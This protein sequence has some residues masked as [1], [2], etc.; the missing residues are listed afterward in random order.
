MQP[1]P[2]AVSADLLCQRAAALIDAGR[3][4]AARPLLTAVRAIAGGSPA[5]IQLSVRIAAAD[6]DWTRVLNELD[7]AIAAEPEDNIL[8][9]FRAEARHRT[10]DIEGAARDAAEAVVLNRDDPR[11]KAMLGA[12]LLDLGLLPDATACLN[13][14]VI[15]APTE[16]L[17]R[18]ALS[19]ALERGGDPAA[20]LEVLTTGITICPASLSL[21][22]AAIL[23]CLRRRNFMK[24]LDLAETAR[25][26]GV[27]N[28]E[29]LGMKGH[30]LASLCRQDEANL[31]Y[32]DALK[33]SPEDVNLRNLVASSSLMTRNGKRQPD[34]FI[35]SVF[36]G[37]ADR[38]ESHLTEL[39]YGI[40]GVIRDALLSH[41]RIVAGETVGPVLDIGCGTGLAAM[42]I[43]D[44]PVGPFT[45]IDLSPRMLDH[46]RAKHLYK[47][48]WEGD[49]VTELKNRGQRWP[50]IIAADVVTYFGALEDLLGTVRDSLAPGGW[51]VFSTEE[52]LP[53]HDGVVPGNGDYAQGRQGR[54]SHA[55]HYV[56]EAAHEAGFRVLRFDRP[57][58][59]QEAG[60]DVPG[61][62]F[63]LERLAPS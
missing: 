1:S 2:S 38:F 58:I 48:L 4:N 27:L 52:L 17:Y 10:G 47:E 24:A 25:K 29:T 5:C 46:A 3:I 15:A 37:Y 28:A 60:A 11:A 30:A 18:E 22:N 45:G 54:Y 41:P 35:R 8:R 14:A 39:G 53:D 42:A 31:A 34:T 6:G 44:L 36:D 59:R 16:P 56:Y 21:R 23:L 51:F 40:P 49:I 32:Q 50:L 43:G 12:A 9:K 20:A 13:E 57:P 33:L 61:L 62:L 26:A 19:A 7:T 63:T 55:A